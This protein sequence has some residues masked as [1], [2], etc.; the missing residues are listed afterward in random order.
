MENRA[1]PDSWITASSS[2]DDKHTAW[3]ARL[4]LSADGSTGGG[5]SARHDDFRQWLKVELGGYTTVTR[6]AT[7]G[8]SGRNEWVTKYRLQ[9]SNAGNIFK[10]YRLTDNS[11]AMVSTQSSV[12]VFGKSRR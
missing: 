9:Y 11:S 1:I 8:G 5:W 3:Q 4:H 2:R 12:D 7:Q 6:V 10:Y